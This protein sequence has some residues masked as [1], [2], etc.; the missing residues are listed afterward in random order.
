MSKRGIILLILLAAIFLI[1]CAQ[2]QTCPD[3]VCPEIPKCPDLDCSS[4]PV[5]KE[6]SEV[7]KTTTQYVCENGTITDS[8]DGCKKHVAPIKFYPITTNEEGSAILNATVKPACVG[9]V[10]GQVYFK[11]KSAPSSVVFQ[12]KESPSEEFK[13]I[14]TIKPG[15]FEEYR[16]FSICPGC[17]KGD[18]SLKPNKVY[19]FRIKFDQTNVYN[20][21]EYSNEHIIDTTSGSDY[22][23]NVCVVK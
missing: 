10:G 13:D 2:Q 5:V 21:I 20:R 19:L 22:M 23:V 17:E 7:T 15:L 12:T 14:Y 16:L 4:C 3:C 9:I 11:V 6:V 18:F 1:G 8:A